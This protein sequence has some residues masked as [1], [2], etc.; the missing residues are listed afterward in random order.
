MN[1]KLGKYENLGFERPEVVVSDKEYQM[2]LNNIRNSLTKW[3]DCNELTQIGS[4]V[5]IDY[6]ATR[7]GELI[8]DGK[9]K[10]VEFVIGEGEFIGDIEKLLIGLNKNESHVFEVRLPNDK[11][12][13]NFQGKK[14]EYKIRI[15]KNQRLIYPD[16]I[17]EMI[18][19]LQDKELMSATQLENELKDEI[20]AHKYETRLNELVQE[21][22]DAIVGDSTI[23]FEQDE[24]TK[25][26]IGMYNKFINHLKQE[27]MPI[28]IYYAHNKITPNRFKKKFLKHAEKE[29]VLN[30]ILDEIS[31]SEN[32]SI[33]SKEIMSKKY[34]YL[35]QNNLKEDDFDNVKVKIKKDMVRQKTI[36]FLTQANV[37]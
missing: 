31:K 29:I 35:Y 30:A 1:I 34:K 22:V 6:F 15:K 3:K 19:L 37:E 12:F 28:E 25:K 14:V 5:T 7:E 16:S 33:S 8:P 24:I 20:Y 21:I 23:H 18:Q 13:K 11:K 4:K 27:D 9:G 10:N 26:S 36:K 32:I 2:A 17:E